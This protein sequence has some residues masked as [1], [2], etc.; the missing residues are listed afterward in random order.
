VAVRIE[1]EEVAK[2]LHSNDRAGEGFLFRHGLL[3]ENFQRLPSAAAEGGNKFSVV[4]KISAKN[5]RNAENEMAVGYLFEGIHAEPFPEFHNPFLVTRR[6]EMSS[7]TRKRQQ[8][9]MAAVFAFHAGK[10]MVQIA[11]VEITVNHLLKIR[12]PE[13]VLS[14]EMFIVVLNK[15]FKIVLYTAVVIRILRAAWLVNGGGQWHVFLA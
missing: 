6:A 10:A 5:L 14:G 7:F 4:K 15:G 3:H 2:G 13:S 1:S 12:T 9:F 8:V 11:A